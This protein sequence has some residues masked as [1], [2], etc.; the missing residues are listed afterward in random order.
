M[1]LVTYSPQV[2]DPQD[3]D[4]LRTSLTPSEVRSRIRTDGAGAW[5]EVSRLLADRQRDWLDR[6][7]IAELF[8]DMYCDDVVDSMIEAAETDPAI[9]ESIGDAH[10]GDMSGIGVDRL[11]DWQFTYQVARDGELGPVSDDGRSL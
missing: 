10:L 1:T 5:P 6:V 2:Y 9:A 4:Q 3:F 11:G 7:A 8:I